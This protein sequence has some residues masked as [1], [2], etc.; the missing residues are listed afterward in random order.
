MTVKLRDW[1]R[2]KFSDAGV[3]LDVSPP[4]MAAWKAQVPW[5]DIVRVCFKV[6][7]G[8]MSSGWYL[9]TK[10]RPESYAVPVEAD[11]GDSV[12]DELLKRKLFDAEL[13]IQASMALDGVFWWPPDQGGSAEPS[14]TPDRG[15]V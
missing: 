1:Y 13:A 9:F 14:A 11:G 7:D 12:L 8:Q 3:Q 5:T 2:V 10:D 4:G 6:E 15:G